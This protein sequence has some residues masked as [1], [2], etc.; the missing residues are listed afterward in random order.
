LQII[1]SAVDV[2][3]A[4]VADLLDSMPGRVLVGITGPPG[5]GKSTV[6]HALRNRLPGA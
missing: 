6:A 4:E 1:V 2:L 3:A 5:A